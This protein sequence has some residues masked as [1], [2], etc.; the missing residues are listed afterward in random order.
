MPKPLARGRPRL[1]RRAAVLRPFYRPD[2]VRKTLG[3]GLGLERKAA[4]LRD[5]Y[6]SQRPERS[7]PFRP[8]FRIGISINYEAS[9]ADKRHKRFEEYGLIY[10]KRSQ[11]NRHLYRTLMS[12]IAPGSHS[13]TKAI[14]C[15]YW[16]DNK[17]RGVHLLMP[18]MLRQTMRRHRMWK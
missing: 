11:C 8:C 14:H 12:R 18:P 2:G 9:W 13:R 5:C 10:R 16:T 17:R 1:R 3:L 15:L 7:R 4:H 6:L